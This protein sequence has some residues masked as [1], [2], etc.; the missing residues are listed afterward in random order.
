MNVMGED[1]G[2][3]A[4]QN[5]ASAAAASEREQEDRTLA[6]R[7]ARLR[8]RALDLTYRN[9]LLDARPGSLCVWAA[10]ADAASVEDALAAGRKVTLVGRETED[11][12]KRKSASPVLHLDLEPDAVNKSAVQIY[13]RA[14]SRFEETGLQ[15]C[16]L[17]LGALQWEESAAGGKGPRTRRAPLFLQP[18]LM[19][20]RQ[21]AGPYWLETGGSAAPNTTL[22]EWL[23]R[24][25]GVRVVLEDPLPEDE[26][27]LDISGLLEEV[28]KQL[29]DAGAN[30]FSV[31]PAAVLGIFE[32]QRLAL[33]SELGR[34][35]EKGLET[36]G[37]VAQELLGRETD[38]GFGGSGANCDA[39]V[40]EATRS[41]QD[42]PCPI[43]TDASQL[44]AVAKA[45][46][47][48]S[49]VLEGPPGTGKSQTIANIIATQ[50]A[51]GRRVLFCA[52]KRAAIEAVAT[53][54]EH[55]GLM[56]WCLDLHGGG[57]ET[58]PSKMLG[59]ALEAAYESLQTT[60]HS[61]GKQ[62]VRTSGTSHRDWLNAYAEAMHRRRGAGDGVTLR[63]A[64]E[65]AGASGGRVAH[66]LPDEEVDDL[67]E[68]LEAR[69]S[70]LGQVVRMRAGLSEAETKT[71]GQLRAER[72]MDAAAQATRIFEAACALQRA[73]SIAREAGRAVTEA[74]GGGLSGW[75]RRRGL[76]RHARSAALLAEKAKGELDAAAARDA[77]AQELDDDAVGLLAD[78]NRQAKL[79]AALEVQALSKREGQ[80]L[81]A[82][83][84]ALEAAVETARK[85][86][87]GALERLEDGLRRG[88]WAGWA[89][90][91]LAND[92]A[93][94]R[95]SNAAH[96]DHLARFRANEDQWTGGE[97]AR[98]VGRRCSDRCTLPDLSARGR[99]ETAL[100]RE[101]KTLLNEAR[102]R[103]SAK[104]LRRILTECPTLAPKLKPCLML[105][106]LDAARTLPADFKADL[107]LMDEAS[108]IRPEDAVGVL[109]RAG[110]VILAGDPKQMPP[111]SFFERADEEEVE[112]EDDPGSTE[113]V[114]DLA[115][116]RSMPLHRLTFHYRSRH[117]ALIAFSNRAYYGGSL[118]T[119]P[120]PER[121]AQAVACIEAGGVYE[122]QR[123]VE[124]AKRVADFVGRHVVG[125][126]GATQSIGVVTFNK[127]QQRLVEDLLDKARE[128]TPKLEAAWH[129][130]ERDAPCVKNLETAQGDERD[131]VVLSTTFGPDPA[132][133]QRSHFGPLNSRGGERRL[134]V[135][136]TR[137]RRRMV[138]VT[139]LERDRIGTPQSPRGV[140]D[141]KA[142][143]K[144]AA[145][146]TM[147][148]ADDGRSDGDSVGGYESPLEEQ[149][150]AA[151]E[152]RG[153]LLVP[154]V[155]VS[156]YRIDI[157]VVDPNAPGR[158]LAGIE[159]DGAQYHGSKTA[160][161]RDRLRQRVLEGKGC[162]LLRVWSPD[163]WRESEEVAERLDGALR[164]L[165]RGE[166][167]GMVG[168]D[169]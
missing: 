51:V 40:L 88:W 19:S 112:D 32:Y 41:R 46:D 24:E 69:L 100:R 36:L 142:F 78:P 155:G 167:T 99:D 97:A 28:R 158:Y 83:G 20:R 135:A 153:W 105:S 98:E 50:I 7:I 95:W 1:S 66:P 9:R 129:A 43:E 113:S 148:A 65:Q 70:A 81:S 11:Q 75:W 53:R 35:G 72:A 55:A 128:E 84:R 92:P 115:L 45:L 143:L 54:L 94:R 17:G 117:E 5:S 110:Q 156:G 102:K 106:P 149:I 125:P 116:G 44:E 12:P 56:K 163:W 101:A 132:G 34:L 79:E 96:D 47:G 87:R 111:T 145:T 30:Q 39:R 80:W 76:K 160:R 108:Q 159:A 136:L 16:F 74:A 139:S 169:A 61:R 162:T 104:P 151:L 6:G 121:D 154:Q 4:A 137:A 57:G 168:R 77:H 22:T 138:V 60:E 140:R 85:G 157:G 21:A 144:Y 120:D 18:V 3:D 124:E 122:A 90:R 165:L 150:A 127:K 52:E 8:E 42:L 71:F 107:V 103:R 133:R 109:A 73:E 119:F 2:M 49:F 67:Q 25:H 161:D 130:P 152:A 89:D 141:L 58:H 63:W 134:N 91:W 31:T 64:M 147:G 164:A 13:R 23:K 27:G 118:V 14:R 166:K 29:A 114:L 26:S 48:R 86:D 62:N 38:S 93:L 37:A 123:N 59:H 15:T 68:M 82:C 10:A 146:G 33:W 131:V 126:D